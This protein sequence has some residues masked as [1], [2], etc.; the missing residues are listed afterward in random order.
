M[1]PQTEHQNLAAM[2]AKL[3]QRRK[4][5]FKKPFQS[6]TNVA[7]RMEQ[8]QTKNGITFIND[9]KAENINATFFALQTI[10]K[11]VIWIAGGQDAGVDYWELMSL[12]R[13]KVEAIVMIGE[14][15]D[16][17]FHIFSPVIE[18]I[19]EADNMET[20]VKLAYKISQTGTNILLSPACKPDR[21][22]MDYKD[23]GTQFINAVKKI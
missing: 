22:F 16:R 17:L 13:Q 3:L 6:F 15:N 14:N 12:V 23:R 2:T 9:S 10:Q 5:A 18:Q 7:N 21:K 1:Q 11:P 8:V 19:Y 20:A 4:Q